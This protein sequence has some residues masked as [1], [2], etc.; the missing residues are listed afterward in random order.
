MAYTTSSPDKSVLG[1]ESVYSQ[2]HG[3]SNTL[4]Y[5]L[6]NTSGTSIVD[7]N[8]I[9][10]D[11]TASGSGSYWANAL[12]WTPNGTDDKILIP[13]ATVDDLLRMDSIN[14]QQIILAFDTYYDGGVTGSEGLFYYGEMNGDGS[15]WGVRFQGAT[16]TFLVFDTWGAGASTTL[17]TSLTSTSINTTNA[18]VPILLDI[19]GTSATTV[20]VSSYIEG[21]LKSTVSINL[22]ANSA[23]GNPTDGRDCGGTIGCRRSGLASYANY[24]NSGASNGRLRDILIHRR[25]TIDGSL[26]AQLASQIVNHPL[27][28]HLRLAQ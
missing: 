10:S 3:L 21:A 1:L 25:S 11:A 17:S 7:S 6:T 28:W 27:D 20:S 15:G 16:P 14:G 5:R 13:S 4:I 24:L 26:G 18:R 2:V 9:G 23:T 19:Q 8:G 12:W 22:R